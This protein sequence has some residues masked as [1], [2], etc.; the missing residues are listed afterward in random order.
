LVFNCAEQ[1]I[2]IKLYFKKREELLSVIIT[3]RRITKDY[4]NEIRFLLNDIENYE[5]YY[6]LMPCTYSLDDYE[7]S[8]LKEIGGILDENNMYDPRIFQLLDEIIMNCKF[9]NINKV[10]S[11]LLE[12]IIEFIPC[13]YQSMIT[14]SHEDQERCNLIKTEPDADV[15]RAVCTKTKQVSGMEGFRYFKMLYSK[16]L[17]FI[18]LLANSKAYFKELTGYNEFILII[19]ESLNLDDTYISCQSSQIIASLISFRGNLLPKIEKTN[20]EKLLAPN[21]NLIGHIKKLL[22]K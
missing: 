17:N 16:L 4:I 11:V 2:D 18:R 19:L 15:K 12:N 3:L 8:I 7:T 21:L 20:K 5:K 9:T 1:E 22:Q 10:D 14:K 13:V 6:I